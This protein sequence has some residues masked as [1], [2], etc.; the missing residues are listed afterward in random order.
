MNCAFPYNETHEI[1][2][3]VRAV[4]HSIN[5]N[6]VTQL[7]SQNHRKKPCTEK[8]PGFHPDRD[9][10]ITSFNNLKIQLIFLHDVLEKK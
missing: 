1:S 3:A 9:K 10:E 5:Q 2:P 4:N 8:S 6:T 7:Q